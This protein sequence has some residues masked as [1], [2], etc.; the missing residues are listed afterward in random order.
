MSEFH[1][2]ARPIATQHAISA[3]REYLTVMEQQML[4]VQSR[5]R[6]K[7]GARRSSGNDEEEQSVYRDE[8]TYIEQLF[9]EELIPT[10]RYSFIVFLHTILETQ[11]RAFCNE[12]QR[13]KQL[14]INVDDITGKGIDKARI[15]LEK[16]AAIR[17]ADF[18]EWQHLRTSQKIRNC[19]VHEHGRLS[20]GSSSHEQICK[21]T[22]QN[23]GL[24][25]TEDH[26]I[27]LAPEFC[28]KNLDHTASFFRRLF[29]SVG[30]GTTI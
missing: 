14:S 5:E 9:D 6:Q 1:F 3:L 24:S 21:L 4:V 29:K 7:V 22:N 27:C 30:W 16:L 18:P 23:V 15:Y 20:P 25:V 11:L 26:R 8:L 13:E 12:M 28:L 19:I 2:D 10:M 17:I